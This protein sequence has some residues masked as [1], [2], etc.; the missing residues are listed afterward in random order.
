MEGIFMRKTSI[1]APLGTSPPVITEFL[2]YVQEAMFE[3]VTDL[4]II[5]TREPAVLEGK[6]LVK[7]AVKHRYP[8]VH[9]HEEELPFTDITSDEDHLEFMKIC[10]RI[11]REQREIHRAEKVYLCVAGGRK[12]M[13]I[14]LSLLGQYFGVN[15]V[16]HV[17]MPEIKA[18][19]AELERVR[20]EISELARAE[21]KERYYKE[22]EEIF[23]KL[24]YP[25]AESYTVIRIPIIPTPQNIIFDVFKLLKARK[26]SRKD[27][28]LPLSFLKDLEASK[29]IKITQNFIYTEEIGY[30][31]LKVLGEVI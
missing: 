23:E 1:I 3:R 26:V 13:C 10:A 7:A 28:E 25:P 29:I 24:M 11:L 16:F 14:T 30:N 9:I 20:Y 27:V 8:M 4:T 2:Q 18:Y 15:G 19:S 31:I 12:D 5:V 17:I 21:D 22:R 6:E